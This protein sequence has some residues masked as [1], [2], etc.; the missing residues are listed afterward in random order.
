L[1]T[2]I[3]ESE[4]ETKGTLYNKSTQIPSHTDDILIV[5]RPMDVLKETIKKLVKGEWVMGLT[6]NMQKTRYMEVTKQL[7]LK[8]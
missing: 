2:V 3:R 4:I 5:G 1:E 7:I 6:I 8:C